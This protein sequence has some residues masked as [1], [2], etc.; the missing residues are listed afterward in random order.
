LSAAF[1]TLLLY[2]FAGWWANRS[3]YRGLADASGSLDAMCGANPPPFSQSAT[4][5]VCLE[6]LSLRAKQATKARVA[7]IVAC[8]R[9]RFFEA[10]LSNNV[11]DARRS[12]KE[13][14]VEIK[15]SFTQLREL[16]GPEI[17]DELPLEIGLIAFTIAMIIGANYLAA[18]HARRVGFRPLREHA[19]FLRPFLYGVGVT[20]GVAACVLYK[21][22]V[23]PKKSSFDWNS[24]CI[25]EASSWMAHG[26]ILGI[27]LVCATSL[28]LGWYF[29]RADH[30]PE[31]NPA[32]PRWGVGRYASFLE[33]WSFAIVVIVGVL[34]AAWIHDLAAAP[35][36]TNVTMTFL[37]TGAL[38]CA[39]VLVGRFV[40]CAILLRH[41]LEEIMK[42]LPERE[43]WPADPTDGI[44]GRRWWQLPALFVVAGGLAYKLLDSAGVARLLHGRP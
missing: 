42:A 18:M 13:E 9:H 12:L 24:Y 2:L 41:S 26:A 7:L 1:L 36:R 40:R 25:S 39:L 27:S 20:G 3:G 11:A 37:G 14:A 8:E 44:L 10:A 43:K 19:E 29:T 16:A 38:A 22:S 33:T 34:E 31:A 4:S 30:V 6:Q 28:G 32:L 23:D 5:N 15:K 35:S 17:A 21:E